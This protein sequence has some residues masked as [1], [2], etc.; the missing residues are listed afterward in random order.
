MSYS[1]DQSTRGYSPPIYV[2]PQI[3][4]S[5]SGGMVNVTVGSKQM[6]AS[7]GKPVEDVKVVIP[8]PKAV[9]T[10]SLTCNVGN[11]MF[12][13]MTKVL[14]WTINKIPNDKTPLIQGSV[15]FP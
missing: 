12:D 6:S 14:E 4:F 5:G 9:S 1:V 8:F 7:G 13:D 15:S 3:S 2:K 10:V 11:Y